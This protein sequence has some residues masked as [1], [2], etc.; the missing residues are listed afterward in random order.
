MKATVT[1]IMTSGYAEV[2]PWV[3]GGP[4]KKRAIAENP[5]NIKAKR[6]DIVELEPLDSRKVR[7]ADILYILPVIFFILGIVV[8]KS[9]S[10]GERILSGA[11]V[12][13]MAFIATWIIN[14]R[15][16]MIRRQEYLIIRV[17]EKNSHHF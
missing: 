14:R 11:I 13:F 10:W 2:I 3:N 9:S 17:V 15:S 6:G 12:G 8:T 5:K 1:D 16:R 7:F 4:G